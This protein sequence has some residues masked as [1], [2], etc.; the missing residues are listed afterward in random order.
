M[1]G[2]RVT[3]GGTNYQIVG[4]MT[5]AI[6]AAK[7]YIGRGKTTIGGTAY[8]IQL[9]PL[10]ILH[11]LKSL[12]C[13][14]TAGNDT[15]TAATVSIDISD[16]AYGN[17]TYFMCVQFGGLISFWKIIRS[18]N[19]LTATQYETAYGSNTKLY[20]A[21]NGTSNCKVYHA[22]GSNPTS[23]YSGIGT[24]LYLFYL[25]GYTVSQADTIFSAL[26]LS[27]LAGNASS[28]AS[29]KSTATSN[30]TGKIVY[31]AI[32]ENIGFTYITAYN[33]YKLLSSGY[34][35]S[36]ML[37]ITSSTA[38]LSTTGTSASSTYGGGIGTIT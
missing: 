16:F 7:Y 35:E 23:G 33:N 20:I 24:G 32:G 1:S 22:R 5:T 17:G 10:D 27:R 36:T 25:H 26:T 28:T 18:G 37:Y 13:I 14:W 11:L 2:G 9:H 12:E 31:A 15:A 4:G 8:T 29:T 21:N 19:T 34:N 38:S 3:I 30:C 6:E